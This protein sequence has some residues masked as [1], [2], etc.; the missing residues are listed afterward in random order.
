MTLAA[1][2][3]VASSREW[4]HL[5]VDHRTTN[6]GGGGAKTGGFCAD[7]SIS[8]S[9]MEFLKIFGINYKKDYF[10]YSRCIYNSTGLVLYFLIGKIPV[11]SSAFIHSFTNVVQP[12]STTRTV[13]KT[14]GE[15][16]CLLLS[17]FLINVI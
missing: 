10:Q 14:F 2:V 7:P 17:L 15:S 12:S 13:I 16:G 1:K 3:F 6:W 5:Q 4:Q 11:I 8:W 9:V